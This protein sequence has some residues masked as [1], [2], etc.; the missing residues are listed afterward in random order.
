VETIEPAE[1]GALLRSGSI[2][3]QL[4]AALDDWACLR[5]LKGRGRRQLLAVARAV[6]PDPWR[7]RLR[8]ALEPTLEPKGPVSLERLVASARGD[9]LPPATAVLLA[10]LAREPFAAERVVVVL[11]QVWQRHP[12]DFWVNHEL[13]ES[14]FT[15]GPGRRDEAIGFCRT[16]VAL[17]PQSPGAHNRL[18]AALADKGQV[19]E[20]I[21]E[22]REAIRLDKAFAFAHYNLGN[23]LRKKGQVDEAIACY[24]EAIRLKKDFGGAHANLG[25][26]LAGSGRL[27][28]AIACF[29]R[30]IAFDPKS[31]QV[32][33]NLGLAL[34]KQ[35]KVDEAIACCLRA[36]DANPRYAQAHNN[37]GLA[38]KKKGQ[39]DEAIAS[40]RRAIELDPRHAP[41][42]NNLGAALA[43]RGEV[44][45]AIACFRKAITADP[46][47]APAHNNLGV[48]L[49]DKGDLEGA[50]ACFRKAIA[51]DPRFG[52]AYTN[53]GL[54]LQDK[55]E[56]E[57]AITW[58]RQGI[59]AEP[60]LADAHGA[61]GRA[62]VHQGQFA[63]ALQAARHCL[64]LLPPRHPFRALMSAQQQRCQHLLALESRL[65]AVLAGKAKPNDA[66]QRLAFAEVCYYLK[67]YAA[68]ARFSSEAF[69]EQPALA[70]NL[71]AGQRYNAACVA[72]LAGCGQGKDAAGLGETERLR[73]RQQALDWLRADLQA[74]RRLLDQAPDKARP[75]LVK[76]MQHWLKDP[77][78][79]GV[80]GPDALTRLSE[81]ERPA[82]QKLWAD[83]ADT[84]DWATGK[85]PAAKKSDMR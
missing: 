49:K 78:F 62:L 3:L 70:A 67:R 61:L 66:A 10:R 82:W 83:V 34:E 27:D 21:V 28:E 48:A 57:Q 14:L 59:A 37:L 18:G 69:A 12:D 26:A 46:R 1:V 16:A 64:L 36:I 41:A 45:G 53:L 50:I 39:V 7:N 22:Y 47:Y 79:A 11:R 8:N 75:V 5:R 63:Q 24:R 15:L 76:Q 6:D 54:T 52:P 29:R 84:R 31:A 25:V 9:Q 65:P 68:A 19:D 17:R 71:Q 81:A 33:A 42:H 4:A 23:A 55:G 74:W 20:A 51:A 80:R 72:A 44:E 32:H 56:M 2:R 43:T 60:Q 77:D 40:Y 30:A 35:G 73:L 38:L 58:Y 13:A 85:A